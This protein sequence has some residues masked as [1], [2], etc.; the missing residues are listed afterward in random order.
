MCQHCKYK[1]LE[2]E[3]GLLKDMLK[4]NEKDTIYIKSFTKDKL[5]D[6][7][8]EAIK[9]LDNNIYNSLEKVEQ[10]QTQIK[11]MIDNI[12][13]EDTRKIFQ[14]KYIESKTWEQIANI[15]YYSP[16]Y[17]MRLFKDMCKDEKIAAIKTFV[18]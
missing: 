8:L 14:L 7:T 3:K 4:E 2:I 5:R 16:S 10:E 6:R 11:G 1:L 15:I 18:E 13:N 12:E 17:L 9:N